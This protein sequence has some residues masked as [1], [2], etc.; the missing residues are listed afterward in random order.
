ME[1]P[2]LPAA[3]PLTAPT[4]PKPLPLE[5]PILELPKAEVPSYVPMTFPFGNGGI[6]DSVQIDNAKPAGEE[7]EKKS[8]PPVMPPITAPVLSTPRTENSPFEPTP[9]LARETKDL[10][11]LAEATT[12]NL[13]GTDIQIPVPKA[14][15]VTAAAV[16]SV[17]S[18]AA[19]L[20]ATSLFKQ[21]V[22]L[23]KPVINIVIKKINKL[24]NKKV[25]TF[26]RQRWEL[27]RSRRVHKGKKGEL[28]IRPLKSQRT[29]KS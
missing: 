20:T 27:R 25:I 19:T 8:P 23:F 14:E 17:V 29:S 4:L 5:A 1:Q 2:R 18:V 12:I 3:A 21:L 7:P 13:P 15:I 10:P 9:S 24:R 26:G 6:N 16:T 22:S 28:Y 11:Q